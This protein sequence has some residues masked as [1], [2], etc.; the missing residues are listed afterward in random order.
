MMEKFEQEIL[1]H[2]NQ[3]HPNIVQLIGVYYPP[4]SK[5]IPTLIMEYLPFSLSN[6][7]EK[8]ELELEKKY[9][10]LHDVAKGLRYLH[11]MHPS[12]IHHDLTASNVLLTSSYTAKISDLEVS[13]LLADTFNKQPL[14]LP[15]TQY[16][17]PPEAFKSNPVYDHKLDVFSYGCLIL[18]V[19]TNEAPMPSDQFIPKPGDSSGVFIQVSEWER[20][21]KYIKMIPTENEFLPIAK[22]CLANDPE[23]RPE[24]YELSRIVST[25]HYQLTIHNN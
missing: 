22:K 13:R 10:I 4:D 7:L 6:C 12:I 18:H 8:Q 21:S 23:R 5:K 15:G 11:R 24:M 19:L 1:L 2:S 14:K 25:V 3:R 17:M 9:S 20:R 16:V